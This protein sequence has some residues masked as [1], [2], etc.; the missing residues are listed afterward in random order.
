MSCITN[1]SIKSPITPTWCPGCGDFLILNSLQKAVVELELEEKNT[2]IFY[3]V[4]CSGNMA[5]FNRGYGFHGLH[6]RS[7]ANALGTK[8]ANH[9]LKVII[10]AGDGDMYGEGLNHFLSVA[11]GNHDIT[12][13]IHNNERYSLTTGQSSPTTDK[14][15][16]TKSTPMGVIDSPFNPLMMALSANASYVSRAYSAKIPQM[17]ELMKQA[18]LHPGFALVDILQLCPTFNKDHNHPYFAQRIYDLIE[19]DHNPQ[20]KAHALARAQEVEK[21][22]L[23]IFYQDKNSVPYHAQLQQLQ[24]KALVDQW[25]DTTNIE[26]GL[27][28]FR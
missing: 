6:G 19:T 21:F 16:K 25:S 14:G 28:E 8:L 5:D 2:V 23:G 22:P 24:E 11:R 26:K 15:T 18:I 12:L 10:V 7:L 3:G 27:I 20:D 1:Q 4:G 13:I 9:N 17:V